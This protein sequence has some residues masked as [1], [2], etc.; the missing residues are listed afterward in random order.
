[1][2]VSL[3]IKSYLFILIS[4][5]I[6]STVI[7][8]AG[9]FLILRL[10]GAKKCVTA[11]TTSTSYQIIASDIRA[12]AGGDEMATQLDLV[13]AYIE[14]G[15]KQL[16]KNILNHVIQKGSDVQQQEAR[17]LLSMIA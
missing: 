6:S 9:L 14:T 4:V 10:F 16:A 5:G 2:I 11:K 15:K 13:R 12:I 3:F 7:F 8:A 17:H 1:M